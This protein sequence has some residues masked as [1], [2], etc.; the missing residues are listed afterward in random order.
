[1]GP[2]AHVPKLCR[3]AHKDHGWHF[4]AMHMNVSQF[5][6][7]Q[8]KAMALKMQHIAPELWELL[9]VMLA[10][11]TKRARHQKAASRQ[12]SR[13]GGFLVADSSLEDPIE[14]ELWAQV[15][16]VTMEDVVDLVEC[17]ML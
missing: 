4:G 14:E 10:A 5:E 12:Q 3:S 15:E 1:M 13:S 16:D 11:D 17:R 9:D 2:S 7:F 8:I 6:A